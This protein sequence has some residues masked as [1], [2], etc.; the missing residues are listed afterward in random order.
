V[1]AGVMGF[2]ER[3][4]SQCG[5]EWTMTQAE[6]TCGSHELTERFHEPTLLERVG[7]AIKAVVAPAKPEA[8][9]ATSEQV[10][11]VRDLRDSI[12][13]L[14]GDITHVD[15]LLRRAV[16]DGGI[17]ELQPAQAMTALAVSVSGDAS[18]GRIIGLTLGLRAYH[19]QLTRFV[20][21]L[22]ENPK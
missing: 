1:S 19:D 14:A 11:A 16:R 9:R 13:R 4:C 12:E 5:R 17:E 21:D 10:T 2:V 20:H 6:C 7:G 3:S 18:P 22:E 15:D 8:P